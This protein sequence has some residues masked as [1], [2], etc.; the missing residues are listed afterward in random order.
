MGTSAR[1]AVIGSS[2]TGID[3]PVG[4]ADVKAGKIV[5]D[6]ADRK[7]GDLLATKIKNILIASSTTGFTNTS[8]NIYT[9]NT[10]GKALG[11]KDNNPTGTG[12]SSITVMYTLY[13]DATLDGLVNFED[14]NKVLNAYNTSLGTGDTISGAG[15]DGQAINMLSGSG[16]T[17]VPEP[18][19]VV[20]LLAG[21]MGLLAYGW[22]KRK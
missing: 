12:P 16:I 6:Y 10:S 3:S 8:S 9:S 14:L 20:L 5:F 17:V 19:S 22:R 15:F 4:K 2:D 21:L 18:S 11:W 13:G 7:D 1:A